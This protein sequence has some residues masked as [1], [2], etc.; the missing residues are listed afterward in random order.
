MNT[1][2][3]GWRQARLGSGAQR[4]S[5]AAADS[6][7]WTRGDLRTRTENKI[8][9]SF[10]SFFFLLFWKM[11]SIRTRG[12]KILLAAV[13]PVLP[14][15]IKPFNSLRWLTL[16]LVRAKTCQPVLDAARHQNN[17]YESISHSLTHKPQPC[18][19]YRQTVRQKPGYPQRQEPLLFFQNLPFVISSQQQQLA[20]K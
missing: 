18:H 12:R 16:P 20:L 1:A 6:I 5:A 14:F 19:I 15:T 10:F 4:C 2:H 17:P 8:E 3:I 7:P 11:G 13:W 9:T